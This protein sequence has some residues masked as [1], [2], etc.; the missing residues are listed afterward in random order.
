M[1]ESD[2]MKLLQQA[3]RTWVEPVTTTVIKSFTPSEWGKL[4]LGFA[5]AILTH[6]PDSKIVGFALTEQQSAM[7]TTNDLQPLL[8]AAFKG[9]AMSNLKGW[10]LEGCV[11][12]K[13]VKSIYIEGDEVRRRLGEDLKQQTPVFVPPMPTFLPFPT[14]PQWQSYK[15]A[16]DGCTNTVFFQGSRCG[17]A[18]HPMATPTITPTT[19]AVNDVKEQ[20]QPPPP[21]SAAAKVVPSAVKEERRTRG[22]GGGQKRAS[23]PPPTLPSSLVM[24]P[25]P[26]GERENL[27]KDFFSLYCDVRPG[28]KDTLVPAEVWGRFCHWLTVVS[29]YGFIPMDLQSFKKSFEKIYPD[30]AK[31]GVYIGFVIA[32][33]PG[34][35]VYPS[36]KR[37][38]N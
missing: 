4:V 32:R 36:S 7:F 8:T 37:A 14:F 10:T 9:S 21:P 20:Y 35:P 2:R 19:A 25:I 18:H 33:I 5:T 30:Y 1:D 6:P 34:L 29:R 11:A 27:I 26:T 38:R 15:C 17:T 16:Y 24:Q 28:A 22:G 23:S 3:R 13:G 31:D 12:L